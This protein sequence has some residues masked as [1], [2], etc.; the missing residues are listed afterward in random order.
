[1]LTVNLVEIVAI[2]A[3]GVVIVRGGFAAWDYLKAK[4]RQ[5]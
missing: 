4:W 3:G 5:G 2:L 1:M